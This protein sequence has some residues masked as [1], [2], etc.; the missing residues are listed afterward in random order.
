MKNKFAFLLAISLCFPVW[1][2]CRGGKILTGENGHEY[3]VSDVKMTWWSAFT[4]CQANK[5][6]L[7]TWAELCPTTA[8]PLECANCDNIGIN[9]HYKTTGLGN[10]E[11]Y[12]TAT[13]ALSTQPNSDPELY[14]KRA[15]GGRVDGWSCCGN[16]RINRSHAICY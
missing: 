16:D 1:A 11:P 10:M 12:W 15:C 9:Q 3:C 7:A 13:P 14:K 6:H 4:W 2:E 8:L 5:R